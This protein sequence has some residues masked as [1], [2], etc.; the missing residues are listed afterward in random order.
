VVIPSPL[1]STVIRSDGRDVEVVIPERLAGVGRFSGGL[2]AAYLPSTWDE[3]R[4]TWTD[5][6]QGYIDRRG[7]WAI[8]P[9]FTHAGDFRDGLARVGTPDGGFGYIGRDGRRICWSSK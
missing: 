1:A 3:R 8:E 9:R 7:D 5:G 2:A 4:N 6:L